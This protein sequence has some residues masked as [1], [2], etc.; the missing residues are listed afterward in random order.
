MR[1]IL[2]NFLSKAVKVFNMRDTASVLNNSSTEVTSPV[3]RILEATFDTN[4]Q[5]LLKE[6]LNTSGT[7]STRTTLLLNLSPHERAVLLTQALASIVLFLYRLAETQWPHRDTVDCTLTRQMVDNV[8][9]SIRSG[10]GNEKKKKVLETIE[11][12]L[13]FTSCPMKQAIANLIVEAVQLAAHEIDLSHWGHEHESVI[14]V[15]EDLGLQ[16]ISFSSAVSG[17][18][19]GDVV[20]PSGLRVLP[21]N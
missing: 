5:P 4:Q 6:S 1:D 2:P 11:S 3:Q 7:E 13:I 16:E 8:L 10:S 9:G 21:L 12:S 19:A 15:E 20:L 14:N 17:K 18:R